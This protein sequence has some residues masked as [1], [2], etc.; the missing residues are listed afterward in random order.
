MNKFKSALLAGGL[1]SVAYMA[2]D[3]RTKKK[4]KKDG[5]KLA[6]SASDIISM[7]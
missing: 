6:R 2:S 4:I 1:L 5:A 3:K 7:F